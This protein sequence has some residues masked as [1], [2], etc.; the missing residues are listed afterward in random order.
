MNLV[1][2]IFE[3][4][5]QSNFS[6]RVQFYDMQT[7]KSMELATVFSNISKNENILWILFR[8][9][10]NVILSVHQTNI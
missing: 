10:P 2:I 6:G 5:M 3:K 1:T 7:N 4:Q 9:K 8:R